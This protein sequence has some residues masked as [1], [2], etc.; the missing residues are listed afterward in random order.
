[1]TK[2]IPEPADTA[3]AAVSPAPSPQAARVQHPLMETIVHT[4]PAGDVGDWEHLG[5]ILLD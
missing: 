5:W 2:P 1:M 3:A 4:I